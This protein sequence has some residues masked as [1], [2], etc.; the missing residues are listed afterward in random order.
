MCDLTTHKKGQA[1]SFVNLA[2][3]TSGQDKINVYP[4]I[5]LLQD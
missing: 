2:L 4:V 1:L 3:N 5:G